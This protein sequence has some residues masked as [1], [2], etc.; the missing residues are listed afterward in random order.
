[1]NVGGGVLGKGKWLMCETT[2]ESEYAWECGLCA[3]ISGE[4]E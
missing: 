2:G 3:E 1:M 4:T